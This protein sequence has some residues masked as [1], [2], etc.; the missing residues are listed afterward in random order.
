MQLYLKVTVSK[1]PKMKYLYKQ[2]LHILTLCYFQRTCISLV[3]VHCYSS[4]DF[5]VNDLQNCKKE[6]HVSRQLWVWLD[7]YV[8]TVAPDCNLYLAHSTWASLL[9]QKAVR[10]KCHLYVTDQVEQ[11]KEGRRLGRLGVGPVGSHF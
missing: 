4:K 2:Y 6:V 5:S 1:L 11:L 9:A 10:H 7:C 3:K 8:I